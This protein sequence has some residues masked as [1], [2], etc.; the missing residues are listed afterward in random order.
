MIKRV[1]IAL[2]GLVLLLSGLATWSAPA[3]VVHA[4]TIGTET[5]T[6]TPSPSATPNPNQQ[7]D[8]EPIVLCLGPVGCNPNP[9]PTPTPKK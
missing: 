9:Q 7:P 3:P 6:A 4:D 5:P 2:L 8:S 1:R